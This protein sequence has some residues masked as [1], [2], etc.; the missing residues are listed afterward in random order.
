MK[1]EDV[2]LD[3]AWRRFA[4]LWSDKKEVET[5]ASILLTA[6]G[7]LLGFVANAWN[8]LNVWLATVG[9]VLIWFS[10]MFC[11]ISLKT[12]KYIEIGI[13]EAWDELGDL[14][15]DLEKL[16]LK[17]YSALGSAERHNRALIAKASKWYSRA[18]AMF[19]LA[20]AVIIASLLLNV[21]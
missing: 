2:M 7:V 3:L 11:V 19:L 6:N 18:N 16:K 15:D 17:I 8:M 14:F 20:M 9:I 10:A 13:L 1:F 21:R 5:K 4:D 12:R